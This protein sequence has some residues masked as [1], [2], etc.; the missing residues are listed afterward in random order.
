MIACALVLLV[1]GVVTTVRDIDTN[2]DTGAR[3]PWLVL[4]ASLL[5]G[6]VAM[7]V[8]TVAFAVS[9]FSP[10]GKRVALAWWAAAVLAVVVAFAT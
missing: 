8:C 10:S 9:L 2:I 7:V 5:V 6:A 3:W 4:F 1:A